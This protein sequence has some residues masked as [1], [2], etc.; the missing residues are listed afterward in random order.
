MEWKAVLISFAYYVNSSEE[1]EGRTAGRIWR[2]EEEDSSRGQ[3][4]D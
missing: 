4:S 2:G 3:D 1:V